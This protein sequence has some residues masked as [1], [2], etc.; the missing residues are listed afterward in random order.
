[1]AD[2][3]GNEEVKREEGFYFNEKAAFEAMAKKLLKV[4][5]EKSRVNIK[6]IQG[7][8]PDGIFGKFLMYMTDERKLC[9]LEGELVVIGHEETFPIDKLNENSPAEDVVKVL[10][11]I[12]NLPPLEMEEKLD[13]IKERTKKKMGILKEQL[14]FIQSN[15]R[16]TRQAA[17][18][19]ERFDEDVEREAESLL[20]SPHI[21]SKIND[22]LEYEMTGDEDNREFYLI[23]NE[24]S[25][26]TTELVRPQGQTTAGKNKELEWFKKIWDV[27]EFAS[28]TASHFIR[29]V[30]YGELNTRGAIIIHSEDRE[31]SGQFGFNI[32]QM[33][34][35]EKITVGLSIK[36]GGDW[37]PIDIEINGPLIFYTT[38]TAPPDEHRK[39]R[40]WITNPN[41]SLEQSQRISN[42]RKWKES[43]PQEEMDKHER[44][45]KVIK[46]ALQKLK[47]FDRIIVPYWDFIFF[48]HRETDDR[49][50][51]DN[52]KTFV[53]MVAHF[54]Q[55]QRP[56][57][58]YEGNNIL[59]SM[60]Q[61]LF[62]AYE[63]VKRILGLGRGELTERQR[64]M[65][66][67]I[68]SNRIGIR[69]EDGMKG[70]ML[71]DGSF[72]NG[73]YFTFNDCLEIEGWEW[74]YKVTYNDFNDMVKKGRLIKQKRKSSLFKIREQ[75]DVSASFIETSD[76]LLNADKICDSVSRHFSKSP[77][78]CEEIK[79]IIRE[80][81][82]LD[83]P[84][85]FKNLYT[86]SYLNGLVR[87]DV[88][89]G[90]VFLSIDRYRHLSLKY[91]E[92][93]K[94]FSET[95]TDD[96]NKIKEEVKN[97]TDKSV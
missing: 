79:K 19:E 80:K 23:I 97:A 10:T 37:T 32:D 59:I 89:E 75:K 21:I 2:D 33:Y 29:K 58:T 60:P 70:E 52:F 6:E 87:Y 81:F 12:K 1:M 47:S 24:A 73:D 3:D 72:C 67:F 76:D 83:I 22:A 64:A 55:Y 9:H 65:V 42:W 7:N 26:Y 54:Y 91:S 44:D 92:T 46:C 30:E 78:I 5:I 35:A 88:K 66:E 74:G 41:E 56:S 68:T 85:P 94:D 95:Q 17:Q 45:M 86:F 11:K 63:V 51:E 57:L 4:L 13:M 16:E 84:N 96:V 71:S 40:C 8:I 77:S 69:D 90:D 15:E 36:E 18:P 49:R 14:K 50:R 38:S 34:G 27:H 62:I 43:L 31:N 28:S 82:S 53:K 48:Q 20:Y 39:A 25:K 93:L 61:D